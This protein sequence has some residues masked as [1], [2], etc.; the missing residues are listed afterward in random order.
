L[1]L[2]AVSEEGFPLEQIYWMPNPVHFE[3]RFEAT[4]TLANS[5]VLS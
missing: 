5:L 1:A 4:T 3:L 2:L